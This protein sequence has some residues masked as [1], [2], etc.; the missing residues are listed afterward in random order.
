[1]GKMNL[2]HATAESGDTVRSGPDRVRVTAT[3]EGG[4][5]RGERVTVGFRPHA[6][7][8]E[9]HADAADGLNVLKVR[10]ERA[11]YDGQS[12]DYIVTAVGEDGPL[13]LVVTH[14][15]SDPVF[16]AGVDASLVVPVPGCLALRASSPGAAVDGDAQSALV[17][18]SGVA[19]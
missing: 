14:R 1:M 19:R 11:I 17:A 2:L 18:E 12:R 8:L 6:A 9:T 13:E 7:R 4:F 3:D 10:V 5:T 15:P 16:A